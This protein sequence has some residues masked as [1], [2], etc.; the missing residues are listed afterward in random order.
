MNQLSIRGVSRTFSGTRGRTTQALL[1]IDF[2]VRENDFV[3]ILGPSGCG[4]STLL[5]IVAGLDYPTEGRVML[6]GQSVEGP[7]A[8]RGVVFQSYTLFPWDRNVI[9]L[10]ALE[11]LHH[12]ETPRAVAIDEA[13]ELAKRYGGEESTKF[14]NGVLERIADESGRIENRRSAPP[15]PRRG[16]GR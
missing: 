1:P 7:G 6:D 2:D 15:G 10:G 5:R 14:V 9:R 8:D 16:R 12:R 13:V 3:T 11:L 4:K